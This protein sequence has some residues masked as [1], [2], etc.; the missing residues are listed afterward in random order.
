MNSSA[1]RPTSATTSNGRD[2]VSDSI[3]S[4]RASLIPSHPLPRS[5]LITTEKRL[6]TYGCG[7]G[8]R[9]RTHCGKSRRSALTTTFLTSTSIVTLSAAK[10]EIGRASCRERVYISG[11]AGGV[12]RQLGHEQDAG[13]CV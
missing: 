6:T 11:G 2:A 10:H 3:R 1:R 13:E 8:A 7:T 9:S 5:T 12:E 4:S